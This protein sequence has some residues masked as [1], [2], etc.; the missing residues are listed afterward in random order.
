MDFCLPRCRTVEG[1][2]DRFALTFCEARTDYRVLATRRPEKDPH[3]QPSRPRA[4]PRPPVNR[5]CQEEG[6][7]Q[8]TVATCGVFVTSP[9][10]TTR[11]CPAPQGPKIWMFE[12]V[13]SISSLTKVKASM[14]QTRV[15]KSLDLAVSK[16]RFQWECPTSD[17]FLHSGCGPI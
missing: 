8:K 17:F 3:S 13:Q 2:L 10:E 12:E 16:W 1:H 14:D 15:R 7:N 6:L 9:G 11:C 5:K 4:P